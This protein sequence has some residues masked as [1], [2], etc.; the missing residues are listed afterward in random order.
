MTPWLARHAGGYDW[1]AGA[2][3]GAVLA[4]WNHYNVEV[5]LVA[6]R[7]QPVTDG[8]LKERFAALVARSGIEM[9]RFEFVDMRGGVLANAVALP[10]LHRSS[11]LFTDTLLSRFSTDEI[12]AIAA[13]ELAH[14]EYYN[15]ARLRRALISNYALIAG[16][17]LAAPLG[18]LT[19]AASERPFAAM[20]W[21]A[22]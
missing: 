22:V 12:V 2:A 4:A 3:L 17:A 9:P 16:A 13:H 1:I 8:T 18:R 20:L 14:L 10:S 6:L 21:P 5:V 7:A 11:V 19:V 15:R